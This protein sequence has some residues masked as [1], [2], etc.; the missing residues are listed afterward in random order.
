MNFRAY[1]QSEDITKFYSFFYIF[2]IFFG[3][4]IEKFIFLAP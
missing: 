2:L 3:I 4:A 1:A